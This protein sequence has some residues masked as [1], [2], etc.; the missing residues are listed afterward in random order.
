MKSYFPHSLVTLFIFA[1]S[2]VAYGHAHLTRAVPAEAALV[3][4]LPSK[5]VLTFSEPLETLLSK[6]EV[7]NAKTG[8]LMQEGKAST[9]DP[10][11]RT[12]EVSLKASTF[13]EPTEVVVNWK[14]VAKDAHRMQ[15]SYSF[16]VVPPKAAK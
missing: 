10:K 14:I 2:A 6:V 4:A 8:E 16:K 13:V 15:G 5:L 7:K 1:S 9:S 12:L 11:A 3:E